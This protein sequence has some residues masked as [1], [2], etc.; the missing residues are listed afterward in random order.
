M[1][2]TCDGLGL[3]AY[4]D[5]NGFRHGHNKRGG[6]PRMIERNEAPELV[7]FIDEAD[8]IELD[9]FEAL[10]FKWQ[11]TDESE[12]TVT[13]GIRPQMGEISIMATSKKPAGKAKK[14]VAAGSRA[15]AKKTSAKK[16]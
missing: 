1:P 5:W 6:A 8:Q 10:F 9:D 14:P 4:C 15:T 11:R 3:C 2:C 13:E 12:D 7:Y 16:K